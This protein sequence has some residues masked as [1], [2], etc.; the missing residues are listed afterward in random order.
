M[1]NTALTPSVQ[2]SGQHLIIPGFASAHSHAFQ[3]VLRGRTQRRAMH[4]NS[5]WSWRGLMYNLATKLTP[6]DIFH[7]ARLAFAELAMSGVTAVGEFHYIHHAPDG[8]PYAN[9]IELAEQVIEAAREVG[10]RITLIRTAYLRAG[11]QGELEPAQKRFV[12]P[13][14]EPILADVE[15]LQS[16]YTNNPTVRIALAAHSIRAVP[17]PQIIALSDYASNHNLPFH[18]HIAEQ[19]AELEASFREYGQPPVRWLAEAGVLSEQFVAV[20]ATHLAP[21]EIE[22]LG[23]AQAFICLCRTT[24][25]DLGDG[26]PQ[27]AD[28]LKAGAKLCVGVDS[29][30]SPDAFEEIRAVELDDR[31]RTQARHVVAEGPALLKMATATGYQAIGLGD[32]WSADQV[33]LNATDPALLGLPDNLLAD[34]V[35]FGGTPRTVDQVQVAGKT[36]VKDGVHVAYQEIRIAYEKTLRRLGI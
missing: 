35:I 27:A 11:Y 15:T 16:R 31:S 26:L 36:I 23:A 3:R 10:I 25:R 22:A 12:D 30:A 2:R 34:G 28:L 21:D 20:H 19:P 8:N 5:F 4:A 9:R 13:D 33:Y 6:D 24:E 7:I 1:K 18:M 29:H 32:D 17:R 14:L